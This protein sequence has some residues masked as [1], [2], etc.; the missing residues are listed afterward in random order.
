MALTS[1]LLK[2]VT[3]SKEY[4]DEET[5]LK[6]GYLA[7]IV[8]LVVNIVLAIMKLTIGFL[9]SS[10]GVV[11]DGFNNLIDGSS[12]VIALV[13]FKISSMPPDRE[14]PHGHGRAEYIGA[15][16][17]SFMVIFMGLQF[18]K[19]SFERILN[20]KLVEF[21]MVSF[22]LL[23]ISIGVKVWLAM[24]NKDLSK[25]I[26]SKSLKAIY[27]DAMGDVL[28]TSVVV[29]SIFLGQFTTL[30]VD[31]IIGV[32]ISL[33]ILYS[34][35][36]LVRETISPL[37]GEAPSVEL[38]KAISRE[39][40]ALD[41][42]TGVHDL[43][44]HSYGE[45]KTMAI[46]DAEFPSNIEMLKIHKIIDNGEREIGEKYNL[47]LVIH[48]DPLG[49]ESKERYELRNKIKHIVKENEIYKSMHDFHILDEDGKEVEFHIVI[50]GNLLEKEDTPN[51]IK[52]EVE[53]L[54]KDRCENLECT[55]IVD[56][57]Y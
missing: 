50:D 32:V 11:A 10:I 34:G 43:V 41:Y 56:I 7:S 28:I 21:E 18:I 12:A 24:F 22:I 2:L 36:S 40:L 39:V 25:K 14:H 49:P 38:R 44:I 51:S 19:S 42:I 4:N 48:M 53:D 9:I 33:L 3:K 6:I 35:Y 45:G 47:S 57:E 5:R 16:I 46:I 54:V 17:V 29:L 26:S 23:I 27:A 1:F 13:G 52:L 55:I 30:P 37:I 8:G 31:G 15:L 20:P